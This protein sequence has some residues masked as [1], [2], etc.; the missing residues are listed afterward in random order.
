[1][2]ILFFDMLEIICPNVKKLKRNS[3]LRPSTLNPQPSTFVLPPSTFDLPPSS[4]DLQNVSVPGKP[5]P[6]PVPSG[7]IFPEAR[8][9]INL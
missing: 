3:P 6:F 9:L 1:M 8:P 4:F 7:L 5:S 2:R